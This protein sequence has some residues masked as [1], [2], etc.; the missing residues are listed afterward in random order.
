VTKH[1]IVRAAL[2]SMAYQTAD[3]LRAMQDEIGV[4]P[5]SLRVDGGAAANDFL[6][7]FQ[8]DILGMPLVRPHCVETTAWGAAALAGLAVGLYSSPE[9]IRAEWQ[10]DRRFEPTVSEQ[11]KNA[12]LEGWHKAVATTRGWAK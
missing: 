10:V 4:A 11:E 6:M 12:L 7:Q 5:Q 1:H 9:D 8:S 3:V 2:E